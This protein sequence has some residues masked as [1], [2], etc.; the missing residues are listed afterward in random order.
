MQTACLDLSQFR[1]QTPDVIRSSHADLAKAN[2][3]SEDTQSNELTDSSPSKNRLLLPELLF[4]EHSESNSA[5]AVYPGHLIWHACFICCRSRCLRV[6]K[7]R[8]KHPRLVYRSKRQE[9]FASKCAVLH[10]RGR[11][12]RNHQLGSK[13]GHRLL[14]PPVKQGRTALLLHA[15]QHMSQRA[16][17]CATAWKWP[18][19][20]QLQRVDVQRDS[21]VHHAG[22]TN[23]LAAY[24]RQATLQTD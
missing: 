3:L 23:Y 10:I 8:I 18:W 24:L 21:E 19:R 16:Q 14:V 4:G 5:S 15:A 9:R 20:A 12:H 17:G 13:H 11:H 1:A 7:A 6:T 2:A 22:S